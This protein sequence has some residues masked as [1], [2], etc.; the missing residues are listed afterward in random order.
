MTTQMSEMQH[1]VDDKQKTESALKA[2]EQ[3]RKEVRQQAEAKQQTTQ[4]ACKL[5]MQGVS[6]DGSQSL[7]MH[8]TTCNVVP[9]YS[10][11]ED[12]LES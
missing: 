7:Y 6:K 10:A 3:A 4:H 12:V 9:V 1:E 2:A 8:P 11:E 5:Y